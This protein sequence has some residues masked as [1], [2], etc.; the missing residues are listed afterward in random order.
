MEKTDAIKF[1][2]HNQENLEFFANLDQRDFWGTRLERECPELDSLAEEGWI[3][4]FAKE[5]Y[6]ISDFD[7]N[8]ADN[9]VSGAE[10]IIESEENGYSVGYFEH[11]PKQRCGECGCNWLETT[12]GNFSALKAKKTGIYSE[13]YHCGRED[14]DCDNVG[15]LVYFDELNLAVYKNLE[16]KEP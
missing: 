14:S 7:D 9:L 16:L 2:L 11:H 8:A 12:G 5:A 13:Q 3:G 15:S 10:K 6:D 4:E 1:L